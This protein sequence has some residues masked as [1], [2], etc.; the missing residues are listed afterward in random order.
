MTKDAPSSYLIHSHNEHKGFDR[1]WE[2][3]GGTELTVDSNIRSY[4]S[5]NHGRVLIERA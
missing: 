1:S 5:E 4:K 2:V 3:Y